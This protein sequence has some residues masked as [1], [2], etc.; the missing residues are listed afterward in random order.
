MLTQEREKEVNDVLAGLTSISIEGK[1]IRIVTFLS[2]VLV[3]NVLL[4]SNSDF[5]PSPP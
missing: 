4:K 5:H 1:H 2:I 3:F